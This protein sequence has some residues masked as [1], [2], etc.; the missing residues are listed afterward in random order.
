MTSAQVNE[1]CVRRFN[2][3]LALSAFNWSACCS[4]SVPSMSNV[5]VKM[6]NCK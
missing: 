5:D 1:A 2:R 3:L 4:T 6:K